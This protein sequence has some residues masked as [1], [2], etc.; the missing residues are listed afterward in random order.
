MT[1][2]YSQT[3]KMMR[4]VMFEGTMAQ[5]GSG[6]LSLAWNCDADGARD[7]S[8]A[9]LSSAFSSSP[10]RSM[11]LLSISGLEA[12]KAVNDFGQHEGHNHTDEGA[13][14]GQQRR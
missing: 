14:L 8:R 7:A 3:S 6:A 13:Y 5:L 4:T 10:V 12:M 1:F 11:T 2:L 9:R